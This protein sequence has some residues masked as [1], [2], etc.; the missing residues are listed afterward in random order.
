MKTIIIKTPTEEPNSQKWKELG[1]EKG[2]SGKLG[3]RKEAN[4]KKVKGKKRKIQLKKKNKN[5]LSKGVDE[6]KEKA[7]MEF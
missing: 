1:F 7:N 6:E 2:M 5:V 3:W 4:V